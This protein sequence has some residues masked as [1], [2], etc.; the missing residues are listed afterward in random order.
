MS[1]ET[2]PRLKFKSLAERALEWGE[3]RRSQLKSGKWGPWQLTA[4]RPAALEIVEGRGGGYWVNLEKCTTSAHV[5]DWIIQVSLKN[6]ATPEVMYHLI[7]AIRDLL[8][9]QAT[10]CSRGQNSTLPDPGVRIRRMTRACKK[11]GADQ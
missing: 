4:S 11:T 8:D 10:L 3:K 7:R 9:P 5:L 1:D 2:T 6:W